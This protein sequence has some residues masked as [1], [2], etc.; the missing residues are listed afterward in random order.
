M[1]DF[2]NEAKCKARIITIMNIVKNRLKHYNIRLGSGREDILSDMNNISK[3]STLV[4]M[5]R[6]RGC[7]LAGNRFADIYTSR[8]T[9]LVI[10]EIDEF[11]ITFETLLELDKQLITAHELLELG[12]LM[13]LPV[14]QISQFARYFSSDEWR[15]ALQHYQLIPTHT[16]DEASVLGRDELIDVIVEHI[17]RERR[18]GHA[19]RE[20]VVLSG[21]SG[22]GKST[23]ALAVIRRLLI[24]HKGRIPMVHIGNS[25]TSMEQVLYAIGIAL[26]IKQ[27]NNEPWY[28][29]L[30]DEAYFRQGIM[31]LDNVLGNDVLPAE[32]ILKNL[33]MMFPETQYLVTTQVSGLCSTMTNAK[34]FMLAGLLEGDAQTLF[35]RVFQQAEGRGMDHDDVATLV[36]QTNGYPMLLIATAN[37]AARGYVGVHNDVYRQVV[38]GLEPIPE[39][40]LQIMSLVAYPLSIQFWE[41]HAHL[42]QIAADKHPQTYLLMLERRQLISHQ[43]GDGFVIHDAL[44]HAVLHALTAESLQTFLAYIGHKLVEHIAIEDEVDSERFAQ[45][46]QYDML[47]VAQLVQQ[48]EQHQLNEAVALLCVRWRTQWIRY[49]MVAEICALSE[50]CLYRI[51]D[52]HP[53]TSELMFAIGS[54]YGHRG[55]VESAVRFLTQS[56]QK[57]EQLNQRMIWAFS[58]IECALLGVQKIGI[59]ES[60][61]L[62]W[63]AMTLLVPLKLDNWVSR[64][65]DILSYLYMLNGDMEKSLHESDEALRLIGTVES[66]YTLAD[67]YSNRGLIFMTMGDYV[68]ARQSLHRAEWI[69]QKLNAPSNLAAVH[70]RTSAIAVLSHAASDARFYLTQAFRQLERTGGINDLLFAIDICAGILLVEGD[71]VGTL[72]LSHACTQIRDMLKL[73][74]GVAFDE[75]VRRQLI[76]A[77]MLANGQPIPSLPTNVDELLGVVRRV[78]K[79]NIQ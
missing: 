63:R 44:R 45:L 10:P 30:R 23:V 72:Q 24:V 5:I 16:S 38:V 17:W 42:L 54:Y 65:H 15:T 62:L 8:P 60:E 35:W 52:N 4:D 61:R 66:S 29:R 67:A 28:L 39:M 76:H 79:L 32:T 27:R 64:C 3:T 49:G 41:A 26:N 53:L 71:G 19:W 69:Y 70:L 57:S 1:V 51:G 9:R 21:A 77:E 78:L 11:V 36:Q 25:M 73:S 59:N 56:M 14:S 6:E 50:A 68:M 46:S 7:K 43:R 33:V 13:R 22:V 75:I 18:H 2:D 40:M 37:N 48:M 58:A 47:A 31:V 55:I 12:D 34:E 74:R 20:H